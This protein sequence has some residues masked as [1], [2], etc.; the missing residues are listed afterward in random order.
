MDILTF[1]GLASGF[2][3]LVLG[4][5]FL[6]RGASRLAVIAGISPLVVGLTIVAAGTSS[7][8]LAVSV[9]AVAGGTGDVSVGNVI[10]SN[11]FNTLAVLGVCAI[12]APL[13]VHS[14]VVRVDIPIMAGASLL[15]VL[16]VAFDGAINWYDGLTLVVLLVVYVFW[17]ICQSR[18]ESRVVSDEFAREFDGAVARDRRTILIQVALVIAGLVIL[19]LGA[20]LLVDSGVALAR[21]LGV[22]DAII[23]L[24]IIAVG[25]SLPE[26]ATSVIATIRDERDIAVGNVV[27][28]NLFN[29][30]GILGVTGVV[31]PL[32]GAS[33]LAVIDTIIAFDLPVMVATALVCLPMLFKG[34]LVRWEGVLF[35]V[36]YTA[37]VLFLVLTETGNGASETLA[38]ALVFSSP[39]VVAVLG[40]NLYQSLRV[41]ASPSGESA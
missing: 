40:W 39:F 33:S 3:L 1:A 35:L 11:I 37:Y 20:R 2:V 9:Q 4:G 41:R 22:S 17:T 32:L 30:L 34:R 36:A 29:L 10:G 14:R 24:T 16:L 23:G 8:E 28:S 19:V 15:V 6:V 13:I 12:A 27:G 38:T 26:V 5:E 21:D 25:T 31:A 18:N 7:P